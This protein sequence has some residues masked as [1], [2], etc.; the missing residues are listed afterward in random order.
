MVFL[1]FDSK[2]QNISMFKTGASNLRPR[3]IFVRPKVDS[4]FKELSN[5]LAIFS[6]VFDRL[7]PKL[8]GKS[9]TAAQIPTW[10]GRPWFK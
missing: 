3:I 5:F 9:R 6:L 10:V 4:E 7:L 2:Y 8:R 1:T